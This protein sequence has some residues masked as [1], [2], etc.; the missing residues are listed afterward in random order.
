MRM[1][2][3]SRDIITASFK[4]KDCPLSRNR[5][6]SLPHSNDM[7]GETYLLLPSVVQETRD[8]THIL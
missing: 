8:S 7:R 6:E 5:E 2:I 4:M 1:W 3:E